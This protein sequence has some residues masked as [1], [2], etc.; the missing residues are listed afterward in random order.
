[1]S[2]TNTNTGGGNTNCNQYVGKGGWGQRGSGGQGRSSCGGNRRNSTITKSLF[3]GKMKEILSL[4][5]HNHRV[6]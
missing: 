1:M 2:Q 6:F 3:E 4:Q 5:A